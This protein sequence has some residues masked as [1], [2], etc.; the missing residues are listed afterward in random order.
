MTDPAPLSEAPAPRDDAPRAPVS[1]IFSSL[2]G[3]G[4]HL[5]ERHVFVRFAGCPWRCRYCDTPDSLTD[6]G[7]PR[8]TVQDVLERVGEMARERPHAGISLTGGEPLLQTDFLEALLP[9]LKTLGLR[10]H[11]ETSATHPYLF[12]RVA[13]DVDVVAADIKLPSAIGRPFWAEHEEVLRRAGDKAFAKLVLTSQTTDEEME[14]AVNLLLRLS[15]TPP[16]VLQPVTPVADLNFRLQDAQSAA[17]ASVVP[18]PPARIVSWWDWAR[19]KLPS[20]KL[21]SQMH[22]VWG[23]P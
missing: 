18:P 8:L 15:P 23:L 20:V 22:P 2:Q 1:E 10:I 14:E 19:Q 3:E 4:L 12:Q 16:L 9:G 7:H 5:G 21:I 13:A 17:P 6:E 11:L